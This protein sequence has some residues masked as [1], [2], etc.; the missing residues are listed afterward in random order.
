MSQLNGRAAEIGV[1]RSV[2]D[3][4]AIVSFCRLRMLPTS[5]RH[6][7]HDLSPA[8][9][10]LAVGKRGQMCHR[11]VAGGKWYTTLRFEVE[12]CL[13]NVCNNP[14]LPVAFADT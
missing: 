2:E 4:W 14:V 12:V 3:S 7:R 8:R 1:L 6:R 13:E 9:A 5:Q 11:Q 10:S